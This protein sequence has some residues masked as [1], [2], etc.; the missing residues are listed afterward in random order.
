MLGLIATQLKTAMGSA[1]RLLRWKGTSFVMFINSTET[2]QDLRLR[3]GE[4]VAAT[5]HQYVEV[6]KKSVM[7]PSA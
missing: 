2:I 6:R 1:D 4:T 7:F 3:L 5:G